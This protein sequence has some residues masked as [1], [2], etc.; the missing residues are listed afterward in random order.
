[1]KYQQQ[2]EYATKYTSN[3]PIIMISNSTYPLNHPN[4]RTHFLIY[5]LSPREQPL[6]MRLTFQ[7]SPPRA[8]SAD[9]GDEE[10]QREPK[11]D[12]RR[13]ERMTDD[14]RILRLAKA[15]RTVE[16]TKHGRLFDEAH[17]GGV[18]D[19]SGP[20]L[21]SDRHLILRVFLW[22]EEGESL[23]LSVRV[24][25]RLSLVHIHC[26][27][28]Q[29]SRVL[30]VALD[31]DVRVLLLV[32]IELGLEGVEAETELVL[33]S[34][35]RGVVQRHARRQTGDEEQRRARHA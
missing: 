14:R 17:P 34:E 12:V 33:L 30:D 13:S 16:P 26:L 21:K 20:I 23:A 5:F 15:H 24:A 7:L 19:D 8:T 1:M 10:Q 29:I 32:A 4:G 22:P 28:V 18:M 27:L 35:R 31:D 2:Y 11:A 3:D 9:E 6:A 25:V